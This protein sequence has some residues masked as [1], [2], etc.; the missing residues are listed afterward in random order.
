[1]TQPN[2]AIDGQTIDTIN[3]NYLSVVYPFEFWRRNVV[4]SL[5]VQRLFDLHG[6]TDVQSWIY[7][8]RRH[9]AGQLQAEWRPVDHLSSG[10]GAG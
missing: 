2:L 8:H 6:D 7:R 5:N 10:S 1:M 3:L 4:A 9:T